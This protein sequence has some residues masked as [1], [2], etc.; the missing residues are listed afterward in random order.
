MG[1]KEEKKGHEN[2]A[3][4]SLPNALSEPSEWQGIVGRLKFSFSFYLT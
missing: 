3:N 4:T 1:Q 2:L